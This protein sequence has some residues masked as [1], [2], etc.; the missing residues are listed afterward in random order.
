MMTISLN[1]KTIECRH[2]TLMALVL[3]NGY[4]PASLV[5]EVNLEVIRQEKWESYRLKDG[6]AVEL[7]SFV[8]GG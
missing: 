2:S 4:D 7:L 6:D 3:E 8:G 5:A 1:G